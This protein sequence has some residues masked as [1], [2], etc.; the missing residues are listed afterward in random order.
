MLTRLEIDNYTLIERSE[1]DFDNG[2]SVITGETG[3]GKSILLGALGMLMGGKVESKYFKDAEKKCVIEAAFDISGYDFR[4][5]F[6]ENELDYDDECVIRKEITPSGKARSFVNDTPVSVSQLKQIGEMLIDIHSQ[7]Q[8]LLLKD[9][10]FQLSVVDSV[11]ESKNELA[12]YQSDFKKWNGAKKEL[13]RLK[14]QMEN[15]ARDADYLKS[16]LEKLQSANLADGEQDELEQENSLLQNAETIKSALSSVVALVDDDDNA[17]NV[18]LKQTVNLLTSVSSFTPE[19]GS[20]VERTNAVL[21]EMKDISAVVAE[22]ADKVEFNQDRIDF[23]SSR[24]DT[25]Y[26]LEKRHKVNT[27]AELKEIQADLER[28]VSSFSS[29]DEQIASLEAD[30]AKYFQQMEKSATSLSERRRGSLLKIQSTVEAS[31]SL[32]GMPLAKL[33]VDLQKSDQYTLSGADDVTFLFSANKDKRMLPIAEI[34]SGG[35]VSRVMLSLKSLLSEVKKMPTIILDEVDTGI[36]GEVAARMGEVM[37]SMGC[38][39]QVIAITHLPQIASKGKS[40]YKVYKE[41]DGDKVLSHIVKLSADERINEIA[42]MLS[43]K[44]PTEAAIQNAKDL[45]GK[46]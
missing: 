29:A 40:H 44:N 45:L 12:A 42:Q 36:S 7:H 14:E 24:L 8:N 1:I 31:L 46:S 39:M 16:Q 37:S 34:A 23:V 20:L 19:L 41:E 28:R 10:G 18:R 25:I 32:M 43:G 30:V 3:A 5:F 13:E 9:S 4:A 17:V 26:S 21:A 33:T 11:A 15:D 2:F 27:V 38:R 35:E 6:D 22:V